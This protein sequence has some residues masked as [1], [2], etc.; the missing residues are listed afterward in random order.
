MDLIIGGVYEHYKGNKYCVVGLAKHSETVE[1][2][3][4]YRQLYGE[5]GLWVRP[6]NMFLEN[7]EV[8]GKV[9]PRFRLLQE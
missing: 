6:K 3:V 7:V 8:D 5:Y 2:M 1:E 4:V 9:I